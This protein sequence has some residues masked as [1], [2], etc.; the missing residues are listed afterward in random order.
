M[1][2]LLSGCTVDEMPE[3]AVPD[4]VRI[5]VPAGSQSSS[6][7]LAV[8]PDGTAVLSWL[9]ADGPGHALRFSVLTDS[10]WGNARTVARGE[11][12]FVNWADFPSVV[13]ISPALWAA[14]WL[15]SQPAGGYAYDVSVALSADSGQS[16]SE[17]VMPHRD[18]TTLYPRDAGVG[19]VWLDGRNMV[20]ESGDDI[21]ASGMTL[22]SATL[23][24]DLMLSG[25]LLVDGLACDCC[26]T[27]VA[28]TSEGPVAIYRDRTAGEIRDIYV[29]KY[30]GNRWQDVRPVANDNWEIPG[31]PVNGPVIAAQ[32]KTVAVAWFTAANGVPRVQAGFSDDAARSFATPIDV[33]RGETLGRVGIAMLSRGQI[34]VSWLRKTAP[35]SAEVCVRRVS[36]D[37]QLGP[38]HVISSGRDV[39]SFSV[40]QMVRTGDALV[41]A[42]TD[43]VDGVN[44]VMSAKISI[45]SLR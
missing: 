24:P 30:L 10:V 41:L 3:P 1:L 15:V 14:H 2:A 27:D 6:P 35:E 34:A 4:V 7:N 44:R 13:P 11:H 42:W 8:G 18:G 43:Q 19:L 36:A 25:E 40:P 9:E 5:E 37:G 21:A 20:D 17:P 28:L 29:S 26:Q 12:W 23:S 33:A 16:W 45:D 39:A 32:E 31:C 22:R 38:V